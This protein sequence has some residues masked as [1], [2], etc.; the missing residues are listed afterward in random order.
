MNRSRR[1]AA[2]ISLVIIAGALCVAPVFAGVAPAAADPTNATESPGA[3]EVSSGVSGHSNV[4]GRS[5]HARL[6]VPMADT[7]NPLVRRGYPGRAAV[8]EPGG[9]AAGGSAEATEPAEWQWHWPCHIIWPIWPV[10][11]PPEKV[12]NRTILGLLPLIQSVPPLAQFPPFVE[13]PPPGFPREL[14]TSILDSGVGPAQGV[15]TTAP[16]QISRQGASGVPAAPL[17]GSIK[18]PA[19]PVPQRPDIGPGPPDAVRLGYPEFL[20][21]A[22]FAEVAAV[23]LPGLGGIIAITALGGFLGYRQAKAGYVPRAVGT[24]RFLQ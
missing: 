16:R 9:G 1:R 4:R 18:A 11:I 23:A 22:D 24:A 19:A 7:G 6:R 3:G 14:P 12:N 17:A 15:P 5:P 21:D 8:I 20:R 2:V 13:P 10:P